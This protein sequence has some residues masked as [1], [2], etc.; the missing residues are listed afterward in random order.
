MVVKLLSSLGLSF[1]LLYPRL[2]TEEASN[3]EMTVGT[4]TKFLN[5]NL[6]SPA[7]G[8][9]KGH[10][11]VAEGFWTVTAVTPGIQQRKNLGPSCQ[12]SPGGK[13][14]FSSL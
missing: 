4:H 11:G 3:P 8:E 9:G 10:L 12:Q 6:L 2:G 14:R 7:K 5:K 1:C 13:P